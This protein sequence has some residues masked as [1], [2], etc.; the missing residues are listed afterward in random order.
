MRKRTSS[1]LAL[2]AFIFF[3]LI[4]TSFAQTEFTPGERNS[5]LTIISQ[6]IALGRD[7][8]TGGGGGGGGTDSS[9]TIFVDAAPYNAPHSCEADATSAIQAAID[10]AVKTS[11]DFGGLAGLDGTLQTQ[12]PTS[13][14]QIAFS[15]GGCYVI[16]DTL[17]VSQVNFGRIEG[18]DAMLVWNGS[19]STKPMWKYHNV[20]HVDATNFRIIAHEEKS[21]DAAYNVDRE[22]GGV[23]A[24][25]V[26]FTNIKIYCHQ[27]GCKYGF[28]IGTAG[29][30][31]EFH[32]FNNVGVWDYSETAFSIE[33]SQ[34][35]GEIFIGSECNG[36]TTG[37][38]CVSLM[39]NGVAPNGNGSFYWIGGGG[40]SNRIADF[41]IAGPLENIY[42]D[43][44]KWENSARLLTTPFYEVIS[45]LVGSVPSNSLTMTIPTGSA[46]LVGTSALVT[47][48]A[49]E[50][51]TYTA[52]K[53][54]YD[55]IGTGGVITHNA[56]ANGTPLYNP[57][58]GTVFQKV[59]TDGSKIVSVTATGGSVGSP[60]GSGS[61]VTIKNLGWSS[62]SEPWDGPFI[63]WM[64]KGPLTLIGNRFYVK[65]T[66][67]RIRALASGTLTG[68]V[69]MIGNTW[70]TNL[71][72]PWPDLVDRMFFD[73][74]DGSA[75][76]S[77]ECAAPRVTAQGE[78][79]ETS[80]G[81]NTEF[82][83]KPQFEILGKVQVN[84]TGLNLSNLTASQFVKT[85]S[86]KNLVSGTP[87]TSVNKTGSTPLTG[88][89]TITQGANMSITQSG[90][91]ILFASTGGGSGTT[92]GAYNYSQSFTGQTSVVLGHALGTPNVIVQC[93][94]ASD[95]EILPSSKTIA[96]TSPWAVTVTFGVAQTG[97]CV[98][99]GNGSAKYAADM[100]SSTTWTI[101]GTTHHLNT[102]DISVNCKDSTGNKII[103]G[104]VAVD[105]V[106]YD[107]TVSFNVAQ[108]GRVVIQ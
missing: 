39:D 49:P 24:T 25:N 90:N 17:T 72:G 28:R 7:L 32:V 57:G 20:R 33:Q 82:T 101:L 80:S 51:Y 107:V 71:A 6:W 1:L 63:N 81:G 46:Y 96:G 29:Q 36:G 52:N 21:M 4:S 106:T 30:N 74:G 104:S 26:S 40:G 61:P 73:R 60:S 44:G 59:V 79:Y 87:V 88:A 98:V 22:S 3:F 13:L 108:A 43:G 10:D 19:D 5:I 15:A 95:N 76:Q 42:I 31:N 34:A 65:S 66:Y 27:G 75:C 38:R 12:I 41:Q 64:Q 50:D 85:D 69:T 9:H 100:G 103:P 45:G 67:G 53:D 35:K 97:R 14:V 8:S 94:D 84:D 78:Y 37:K 2:T 48:S 23:T 58:G 91:D 68:K 83:D 16:S 99:N 93:Y 54:T 62:A 77:V 102:K 105:P 92:P 55:T 70:R 56:Y 18:N 86:N 47:H 89:V 11:G